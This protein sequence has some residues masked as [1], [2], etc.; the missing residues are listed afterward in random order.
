MV[1]VLVVHYFV[2][3]LCMC[4]VLFRVCG[5][6]RVAPLH[7]DTSATSEL[8][9]TDDGLGVVVG[10]T[11]ASKTLCIEALCFLLYRS[12]EVEKI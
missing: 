7:E 6:R 11:G 4:R 3:F 10:P 1:C 12:A 8:D 2:Y 9:G 5:A